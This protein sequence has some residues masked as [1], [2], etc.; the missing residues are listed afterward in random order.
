MESLTN[1]YNSVKDDILNTRYFSH[2]NMDHGKKNEVTNN[3]NALYYIQRHVEQLKMKQTAMAF[4]R[5]EDDPQEK[6]DELKMDAKL[7]R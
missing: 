5:G 4:A 7:R 3:E 1:H 2:Y 6:I